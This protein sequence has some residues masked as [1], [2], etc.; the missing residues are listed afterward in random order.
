MTRRLLLATATLCLLFAFGQAARADTVVITGGT[1]SGAAIGV[2]NTF[3]LNMTGDNFSVQGTGE[4]YLFSA[5]NVQLPHGS[6]L[7]SS[8][9]FSLGLI[10]P[11]SATYNG[12]TYPQI[13]FAAGSTLF[14]THAPIV[15]PPAGTEGVFNITTPFSMT[16]TFN[17]F[18]ANTGLPVFSVDV[19][20]SG[21]ATFRVTS[22]LAGVLVQGVTY[23]FAQPA[24]V[25][26]PATLVLLGAGL[27]GLAMKRR[28][29]GRP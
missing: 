10:P 12:I 5:R 22:S 25:P 20:G 15:L 1:A 6:T 11:G 23:N 24:A 18:D 19:L 17:V 14:A 16:G 7:N 29:R 27:G 4:S 26:E 9:T 21:I 2:D 8:A 13:R 3:F 28:R